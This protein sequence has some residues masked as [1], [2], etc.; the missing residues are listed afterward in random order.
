MHILS[1]HRTPHSWDTK[2]SI[3]GITHNRS[4]ERS[5]R[6]RW[7]T[8][9]IFS[10]QSEIILLGAAKN[11]SY[12]MIIILHIVRLRS[13]F[14]LK[15]REERKRKKA[16]LMSRTHETII[17]WRKNKKRVK[18]NKRNDL[19]SSRWK[20]NFHHSSSLGA[21]SPR[22]SRKN[23]LNFSERVKFKFFPINFRVDGGKQRMV[24]A[25]QSR[26]VRIVRDFHTEIPLLCC[27]S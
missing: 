10:G 16:V 15:L 6:R 12:I 3:L 19:T 8:R 17:Q 7:K 22:R 25:Y 13:A 14:P 2:C 27:N 1:T 18:R 23:H 21:H 4:H 20:I 11:L 5:A 26:Q 24:G 9:K